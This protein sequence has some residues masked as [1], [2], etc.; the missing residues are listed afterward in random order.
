M[1]GALYVTFVMLVAVSGFSLMVLGF[2]SGP[3]LWLDA[4]G[5]GFI[6]FEY[7]WIPLVVLVLIAYS[8]VPVFRKS[9]SE[10]S[11]TWRILVAVLAVPLGFCLALHGVS[12]LVVQRFRL[13]YEVAGRWWQSLA[14]ESRALL[15]SAG[16]CTIISPKSETS[17]SEGALRISPS[18][19]G[20]HA[21]GGV[22]ARHVSDRRR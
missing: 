14:R 4:I 17:I 8:L 15:S 7:Y 13:S 3:D 12:S 20:Y 22:I 5:F 2:G 19:D 1:I 10:M 9:V 18:P 11:A 16:V 6:A 21:V